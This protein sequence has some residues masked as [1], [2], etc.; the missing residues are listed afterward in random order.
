MFFARDRGTLCIIAKLINAFT[1]F[2]GICIYGL[3]CFLQMAV[4][5]KPVNYTV[6]F[7]MY[8]VY[9]TSEQDA[10]EKWCL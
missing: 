6:C 9:T 3:T 5:E 1:A 2:K 7:T 10:V 8:I 4:L